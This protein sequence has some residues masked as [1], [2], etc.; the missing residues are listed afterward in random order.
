[1]P[2]LEVAI[3]E[4]IIQKDVAVGDR[5]RSVWALDEDLDIERSVS[6][7]L[8]K[9]RGSRLMDKAAGR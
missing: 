1:L 7:A 5:Y 3:S 8:L 6:Q 2:D 9:V 4:P